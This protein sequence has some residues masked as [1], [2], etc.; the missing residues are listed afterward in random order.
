MSSLEADTKKPLA[1]KNERIKS[2]RRRLCRDR[3]RNRHHQIHLHRMCWKGGG[4][5]VARN[6]KKRRNESVPPWPIGFVGFVGRLRRQ[7]DEA[8]AVVGRQEQILVQVKSSSPVGLAI[9]RSVAGLASLD[10]EH[11]RQE[12]L[13]TS[14]FDQVRLVTPAIASSKII[15][16]KEE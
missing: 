6:W 1:W 12:A 4:L 5:L 2:S 11:A 16:L 10:E 9:I 13:P 8:V 15:R 14:P 3:N 7:L